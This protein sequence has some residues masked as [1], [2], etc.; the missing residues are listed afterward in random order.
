MIFATRMN[1]ATNPN[2]SNIE[3]IT[4]S[5]PL[6]V[7]GNSRIWILKPN[8]SDWMS[9][10]SPRALPLASSSV[11]KLSLLASSA[12]SSI[13]IDF[14][15]TALIDIHIVKRNPRSEHKRVVLC[16]REVVSSSVGVDAKQSST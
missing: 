12:C 1:R 4:D 11:I 13:G 5:K 9:Q 10:Y 14:S 8:V 16:T 15:T 7:Y 3:L 2:G 6:L